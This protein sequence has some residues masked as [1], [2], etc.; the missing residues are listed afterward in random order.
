MSKSKAIIDGALAA[1]PQEGDEQ[2]IKTAKRAA[3]Q[4]TESS[5]R[6]RRTQ[7][8]E[9]S[10][11]H[12]DNDV[13]TDDEAKTDAA[14][15]ASGGEKKVAKIGDVARGPAKT[16]QKKKNKPP[17]PPGATRFL[18]VLRRYEEAD[19]ICGKLESDYDAGLQKFVYAEMRR[20]TRAVAAQFHRRFSVLEKKQ[21]DLVAQ[22]GYG[23]GVGGNDDDVM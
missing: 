13:K 7:K 3:E 21:Y 6:R 15:E 1:E 9:A 4:V 23:I 18:R 11:Y 5:K 12:T 19:E 16:A 14:G 10:E 22:R 8:D 17:P 2:F 20:F